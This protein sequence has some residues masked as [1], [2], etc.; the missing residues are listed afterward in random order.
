MPQHQLDRR[1]DVKIMARQLNKAS[2]ASYWNL[3]CPRQV[4]LA[5]EDKV[6]TPEAPAGKV[7]RYDERNAVAETGGSSTARTA[8]EACWAI[9]RLSNLKDAL[10]S[11]RWIMG[12]V[13]RPTPPDSRKLIPDQVHLE[14][15]NVAETVGSA[16]RFLT[17]V[18]HLT[19]VLRTN[20]ACRVACPKDI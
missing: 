4:E 14:N 8:T 2:V 12:S 18:R 7:S 11:Q 17:R 9:S 19:T 16:W 10:P 20:P 15:N 1:S 13:T 5:P 6:F 3:S